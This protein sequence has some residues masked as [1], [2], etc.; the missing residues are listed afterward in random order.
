[1]PSLSQWQYNNSTIKLYLKLCSFTRF[2]R[3]IFCCLAILS[4]RKNNILQN[5]SKTRITQHFRITTCKTA[6]N[7]H[8]ILSID[9]S[10]A[11]RDQH[12]RYFCVSFA[13][14]IKQRR[15][16]TLTTYNNNNYNNNNNKNNTTQ[17]YNHCTLLT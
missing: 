15:C 4:S 12:F 5:M 10:V 9:I 14:S 7:T 1:M 6:V 17:T 2:Q 3:T 11:F 8:I 13:A 16:S